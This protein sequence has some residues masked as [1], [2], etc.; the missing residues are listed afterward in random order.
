M[1][2]SGP[3]D[4]RRVCSA[5]AAVTTTAPASGTHASGANEA[6]E[7]TL[8]RKLEATEQY[9][10]A[11]EA[12]RNYYRRRWPP[13]VLRRVLQIVAR[14][15]RPARRTR[16]LARFGEQ[17]RVVVVCTGVPDGASA[18]A[19]A[20][21]LARQSRPLDAVVL[22]V[23]CE[24]I[25]PGAAVAAVEL[26]DWRSDDAW[27]ARADYVLLLQP[28]HYGAGPLYSPTAVEMAVAALAADPAVDA[29]VL[30]GVPDAPTI[31]TPD[32]VVDANA[33]TL[34]ASPATSLAIFARAAAF[35]AVV[36]ATQS[37]AGELVAAI[38]PDRLRLV[39]AP[40][41]FPTRVE[42]TPAPPGGALPTARGAIRA[43]YVTQFIECGGADKGAVDLV[44]RVDP[45]LV[46]FHFMTTMAS[47]HSWEDRVR[48]YVRELCH[49]SEHLTVPSDGRYAALLVEYVRRREIG[50]VH[51]MHSFA[52]YD[53]LPLLRKIAPRVKVV[54]QC[55][56]LEPPD[57]IEGGHPSYSTKHYRQYLDHRT[58]TNEWLK[59]YLVGLGVPAE[60]V[61]VIYTGVD[62]E[63]EF[64]PAHY[65]AG[66]FRA[67]IGVP[68]GALVVSFIGRLHWQKRPWL[69]VEIAAEVQRRAPDL[70]VYFVVV[71]DGPERRRIEQLRAKMP[72]PGR[73]VLTGEM[74]HAG[75]VL[76]D[77]D[78]LVMPSAHEGLAFVSYEAMAMRVPQVFTD[79][80]A[81][82][83][84]VTQETGVL[85]APDE[86]TV[87]EDATRA[88][89][90]LLRD[91]SRRSAMGIAARGRVRER[92]GITRM[93]RQ[94]E[95]LYR[96]L[97]Q[98]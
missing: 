29:M 55:H 23:P 57:V 1:T 90:A 31:G 9:A 3:A 74:P 85:I 11:L 45:A 56:V 59:R 68:A 39:M 49:L 83:E 43:L 46:D 72:S 19:V 2:G 6:G 40:R 44:T 33:A 87:V 79:V 96:R 16:A 54:D 62:S 35:R 71:G 7:A 32:H 5:S 69:F 50:L 20:G 84:L 94:Y 8:R 82:S 77:T 91:A 34:A 88:T 26:R 64:D 38:R 80:N 22:P 21:A 37:T 76:R 17:A 25:R 73:L 81:Q 70:D 4:V 92:F 47:R 95:A 10:R 86:R 52:A 97:S 58:V 18:A 63:G 36:A 30:R 65:P 42:V 12:D 27:L 28:E 24:Q 75:P 98:S 41:T 78:L 61:T 48:P 89:V 53:A 51:I 15:V 66:V 60:Q 67:Q 93:V 14:K 13:Y